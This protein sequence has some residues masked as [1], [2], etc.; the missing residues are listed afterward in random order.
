MLI[1]GTGRASRAWRAISLVMLGVLLGSAGSRIV[2]ASA[3]A[4]E[5]ARVAG[6]VLE[7]PVRVLPPEWRWTLPSVSL[8]RMYGTPSGP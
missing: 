8:D 6:P 1:N 3:P 7:E 5:C 4:P 2:R